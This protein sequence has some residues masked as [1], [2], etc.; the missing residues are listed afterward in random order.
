M[1]NNVLRFVLVTALV[2]SCLLGVQ[3][4]AWAEARLE[5]GLSVDEVPIG[6]D[7]SGRDIVIFGALVDTDYAEIFSRKFDVIIEVIGKQEEIAV[8]KKERIAG[9]WVNADSRTFRGVPA[10]YSV[11]ANKE[12]SEIADL[13]LLSSLGIGIQHLKAK[14][15]RN[16]NV[17]ELLNEGEFNTALR[18]KMM[19]MGLFSEDLDALEDLS[20][21]LF[22][23]T[24]FLPPSIP[25]GVHTVR[26]HLF[27]DGK[28]IDLVEQ[29]FQV[30]KI[31]FERWI[32]F[33]AQEYGLLH[34]IFAVFLAIF[35][36][37]FADL[38]FRRN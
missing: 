4:S 6:S 34:G 19:E 17:F 36:G 27:Q 38:I 7:F 20:P 21:F 28:P 26:A 22:R 15:D 10:F 2:L 11:V 13:S 24:L 25:T 37:W 33:F 16:D 32:H 8:R 3:R 9:I 23:A 14:P 35:T 30:K 12:L 5:M 31:G 18:R 1:T 29:H